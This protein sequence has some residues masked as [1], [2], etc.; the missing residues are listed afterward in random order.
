MKNTTKWIVR[1][2][3]GDTVCLSR[4]LEDTYEEATLQRPDNTS[5]ETW[6]E[7]WPVG[8]A[9]GNDEYHDRVRFEAVRRKPMGVLTASEAWTLE[10]WN[11]PDHALKQVA[12]VTESCRV[13]LKD[14]G[15]E[16]MVGYAR[17]VYLRYST[18]V[19]IASE[20][21]AISSNVTLL[22]FIEKYESID[23]VPLDVE[24]L[25]RVERDGLDWKGRQ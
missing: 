2:N 20:Y 25:K 11:R 19:G 4:D 8:A 9:Y 24:T 23:D 22:N 21:A 15:T 6:L 1:A 14:F 12:D 7:L 18:R 13:F 10:R 5:V 3:D 16:D 17:A